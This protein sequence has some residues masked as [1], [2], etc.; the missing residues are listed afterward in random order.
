MTIAAML[1]LS[2]LA[3]GL[4]LHAAYVGPRREQQVSPESQ[5]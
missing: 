5:R 1:L 3:V 2:L 4:L